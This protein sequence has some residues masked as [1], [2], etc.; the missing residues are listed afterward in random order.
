MFDRRLRL[1]GLFIGFSAAPAKSLGFANRLLYATEWF[2]NIK[3][4]CKFLKQARHGVLFGLATTMP[5][6]PRT[7]PWRSTNPTE[8]MEAI[9]R[10]KTSFDRFERA[11]CRELIYSGWWLAGATISSYHPHLLPDPSDPPRWTDPW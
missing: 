7:K 2:R 11:V 3:L 8:P 9:A 6:D 1:S 5:D 10:V 4:L